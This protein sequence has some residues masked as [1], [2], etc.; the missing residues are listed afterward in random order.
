MAEDVI[1]QKFCREYMTFFDNLGKKE[2][3]GMFQ[4]LHIDICVNLIKILSSF[5]S[6]SVNNYLINQTIL[7]LD[8]LKGVFI[9]YKTQNLNTFEEIKDF[10]TLINIPKVKIC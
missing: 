5:R 7:K 9:Y 8:L 2:D 1:L 4:N 3:L 6:A 10:L